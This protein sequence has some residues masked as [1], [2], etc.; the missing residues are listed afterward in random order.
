MAYS[1]GFFNRLLNNMSVSCHRWHIM[2]QIFQK[3]M[4]LTTVIEVLHGNYMPSATTYG[5]NSKNIFNL[6]E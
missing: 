6:S 4:Q 2:V 3:F 5:D 1:N